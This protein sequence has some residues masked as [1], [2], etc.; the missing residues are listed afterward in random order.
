MNNELFIFFFMTKGLANLR[1]LSLRDNQLQSIPSQL[2]PWS[3]LDMVDLSG[4][5][6]NCECDILWLRSALL[7]DVVCASPLA[8]SN[9]TL[10]TLSDDQLGC[11]TALNSNSVLI[12]VSATGGVLLFILT[13]TF[14]LWR[15]R[16]R[17][18][19]WS[20]RAEE[21][22]QQQEDESTPVNR[23]PDCHNEEECF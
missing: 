16:R 4:N 10:H 12:A 15:F 23:T 17:N 22:Q 6:F 11:P 3:Q 7:S 19:H 1:R 21:Q 8:V 9:R 14:L 13:L 18:G 5:P 2:A 20:L